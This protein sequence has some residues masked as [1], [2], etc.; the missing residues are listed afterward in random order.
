MRR[1]PHYERE[2][3]AW[4][5]ADEHRQNLRRDGA[6]AETTFDGVPVVRLYHGSTI[7]TLSPE[8]AVWYARM[9]DA[10]LAELREREA[11]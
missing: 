11:A 3:T 6:Y 5:A 10:A 1:D 4:S 7:M 8:Q 9:I 2:E